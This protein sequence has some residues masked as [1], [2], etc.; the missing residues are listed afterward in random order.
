MSIHIP[1]IAVVGRP[2]VGKS[3][4]FNRVNGEKLAVVEDFPGVTR[5]RN[6]SYVDSYTV[7]F[8][9]VDT[10]GF[11]KD[12]EDSIVNQVSQQA[13][14]AVEEAD[15]IVFMVDGITGLHSGDEDVLEVLRRHEKPFYVVAN[16]VDGK[17]L[18]GLVADF[19]QMG[20]DQVL[21]CSALH[22]RGVHVLMEELLQKIPFYT[23]LV[24]DIKERSA[25]EAQIQEELEEEFKQGFAEIENAE[26]WFQEEQEETHERKNEKKVIELDDD[27]FA[28][29]YDPDSD[30]DLSDYED[31]HSLL[32]LPANERREE[33]ELDLEDK[34]EEGPQSLIR[35][36][37][38]GRPNVGKSTLLNAITRKDRSI[39]SP[40]AGTT[41]DS[42]HEMY[43]FQG[44][45]FELIDTAG[46]RKKGRI[47]DSIER[48]SVL[49][50]LRAISDCDVAIVV[51]DAIDGPT[52]QDGK[53]VGLAHDQGKGIVLV[54]NKWD[55]IEKDHTAVKTFEAN[56]RDA[57]KFIPYAPL[58]F[59]SAKT[60][61]RVDRPLESA[62]IVAKERRKRISTHSLNTL[63]KRELPR[64]NAPTYR[65]RKLKLYY[66][67]QVDV[68]PPRFMLVMNYPREAHFSYL[69]FIK[70]VI[71][72]QYGFSGTDIKLVTKKR[73]GGPAK[74]A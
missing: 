56:I 18:E 59:I 42:I 61:R 64:A 3:T 70:N 66:A 52:E 1:I 45:Q 6:Y 24:A 10:G 51:L 46:M 20:V 48:Y 25:R 30:E 40:V 44:Q 31:E 15:L 68:A 74:R 67:A 19:Y 47:G 55:A 36:A 4:F 22:G 53:I 69:R 2:N 34:G 58:Y 11:E 38:I 9:L 37:I 32:P 62:L 21:S 16:K 54:V 13:I 63:L 7:P 73:S 27:D 72:D 23:Q 8:Y 17:E 12:S 50:S 41:R 14:S 71:R 43:E 65:G 57:F 28:P 35:V 26:E 60:G 39:T 33:L 29:V 5:D 49:R